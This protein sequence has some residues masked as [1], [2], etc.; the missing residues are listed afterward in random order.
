MWKATSFQLRPI[1]LSDRFSKPMSLTYLCL[2]HL[3]FGLL[4]HCGEAVVSH[5]SEKSENN[6]TKDEGRE[7]ECERHW[8]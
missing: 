7:V 6:A 4:G 8:S 3:I 1:E 2:G 5:E